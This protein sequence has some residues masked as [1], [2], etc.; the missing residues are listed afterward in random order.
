MNWT[1]LL[2]SICVYK[3]TTTIGIM[4]DKA[5]TALIPGR[6]CR[7]ITEQ[8]YHIRESLDIVPGTPDSREF[9]IIRTIYLLQP[10]NE[11][12]VNYREEEWKASF[13]PYTQELSGIGN[14]RKYFFIPEEELIV[15]GTSLYKKV[16][17]IP[18]DDE[19]ITTLKRHLS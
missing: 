15:A 19:F 5:K 14:N 12:P 6:Y 9:K 11:T 4:P 7:N 1:K 13:D 16:P 2:A 18:G 17:G 8:Q 10:D 3:L